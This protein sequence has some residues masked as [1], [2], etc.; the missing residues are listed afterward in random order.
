LK[1]AER[2]MTIDIHEPELEELI[3][4]RMEDGSFRSVEEVL[5]QAL[6]SSFPT[7]KKAI[8]PGRTGSDLIAAMQRS[9]YKEIELEPA[10]PH[11]PVRDVAL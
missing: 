2:D 4:R 7:K 1:K 9:P 11:M 6:K 10:R 3:R 8:T 5:I